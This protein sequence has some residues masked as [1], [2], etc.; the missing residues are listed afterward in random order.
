MIVK[1]NF[2]LLHSRMRDLGLSTYQ[3]ADR[4]RLPQPTV[5]TI[6]SGTRSPSAERLKAIC[7]V[8][9]LPIDDVFIE[10]PIKKAA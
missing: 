9:D 6:V 1:L 7:D 10:E 5:Q 3:L 2:K 8:L 4:A